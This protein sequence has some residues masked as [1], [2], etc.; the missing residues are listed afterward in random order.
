[1]ESARALV[2]DSRNVYLIDQTRI[3]RFTFDAAGDRYPVWSPDGRSI[4]FDSRRKKGGATCSDPMSP[5]VKNCCWPPKDK[6]ANDVSPDG[7]FLLFQSN[8][9][10]PGINMW[11]LPL[12]GDRQPYVMES[13]CL[14]P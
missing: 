1:M 4:V 14:I 3:N 5:G 11:V 9:P 10:K 8:D 2:F 6:T 7:R 13:S 12:D